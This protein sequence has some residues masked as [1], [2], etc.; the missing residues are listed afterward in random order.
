MSRWNFQHRP[1]LHLLCHL[2]FGPA[3]HSSSTVFST[4]IDRLG[5]K[6]ISVYSGGGKKTTTRSTVPN[7]SGV[8]VLQDSASTNGCPLA[9]APRQNQAIRDCENVILF[10]CKITWIGPS[11]SHGRPARFLQK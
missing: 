6:C 10:Q 1:T 3:L 8:S 7:K 2:G 11:S 5:K 9:Q 4:W